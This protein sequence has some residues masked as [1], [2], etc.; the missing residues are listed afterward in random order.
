MSARLRFIILGISLMVCG[1]A[2]P[3]YAAE[4][5]A[6]W[7]AKAVSVQG[8]VEVQRAGHSAWQATSL[9]ATIC[10]GD[11]IRVGEKG[12]AGL[13]LPNETVV[14]LDQNSFITLSAV[15]EEGP[16]LLDL[17]RGAAHFI[18]RVPRALK[19]KT[20]YVN[21][22]IEGT[23]FTIRVEGD[24]ATIIVFEGTVRAEN[25]AG[26]EILIGGE[27]AIAKAGQSPRKILVAQPRDAVD[28]ALY[29]PPVVDL[30]RLVATKPAA[31]A[32]ALTASFARFRQGDIAGAFARLEHLPARLRDANFHIYSASLFLYVGRVDEAREAIRQALALEP[33]SGE[34]IALQAI[35]AVSQD[36]RDEAMRLAQTAVELAPDNAAPRIA[37]S[38]AHQSRFALQAALEDAETAVALE[39]ENTLAWARLAELRLSLGKLDAALDAASQATKL[40]PDL[41]RTQSILGYAYLLRFAASRAQDTFNK[42]IVLDQSDPLPRLGIGLAHI[43]MGHLRDGRREIEIAAGLDPNN[44]LIRSYLGKAYFEEK[45]DSLA[46]SQFDMAKALDPMD[47][48]PW[49][50]DA[51]RKQTQNRPSEALDDLKQSIELNDNRAVYRSRLLLDEDLA[52]REASIARIYDNLGFEQLGTNKSTQSLSLDPT[53][54]SA[55]RFLADSH[56]RQPRLETARVSELLQTQLLQPINL[57][58]VQPQLAETNLNIITGSGPANP[59][60]NEFTPL[61]AMDGFQLNASGIAGNND[62]RGDEVVL[63]GIRGPF[64]F[65]LGQFYYDTDGFRD[66]ADIQHKIYNVFVQAALSASLDLQF[67]FRRRDTDQGDLRLIF[68]PNFVPSD[69]QELEQDIYRA[70]LHAQ[71]SPQ[72][73][74]LFSAIYSDRDPTVETVLPG[75]QLRE[76]GDT[77][78]YDLQ[79][80]YLHRAERFNVTAGVG[81]YDIDLD[82]TTTVSFGGFGPPPP[83][84]D[85]F[86]FNVEQ[87]N[88]YLYTNVRGPADTLWTLGLSYDSID[89]ELLDIDERQFN[90]KLG[91]QWAITDR[92]S[93]RGA[94]LR[95][96]K[97]LLIANQTIEPT[98][99]AGF[100]QFF[101]DFNAT[102]ARVYGIG[103]DATLQTTL[104]TGA[105]WFSRSLDVPVVPGGVRRVENR[106]E[107][108]YRAYLYWN[109]RSDWAMT[110]QFRFEE[111][112]NEARNP[113]QLKTTIVPLTLRYFSP[114]GPFAQ[115]GTSYVRQNL[116]FNP[117]PSFSRRSE[118][119]VVVDA[120]VGY[121]LP[122]RR[123]I[124]SLEA[125]NLFDEDFL[126]QDLS[127]ANADPF[128]FNPRF[129]PDRAILGRLTLSF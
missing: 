84:P 10:P 85:R 21:A 102:E 13:I 29:Y 37:R 118:E 61:F 75:F 43:R 27:S 98:Q 42:A 8:S 2:S 81:T 48:T 72:S 112:R 53:N 82:G 63:S 49:F 51:I 33:A 106:N 45:R 50:Y 57:H 9:G 129:V 87:Y 16:S 25:T 30:Q 79:A 111:F 52:A 7:A 12:R 36:D 11:S 46:A 18:S 66:D 14:R 105:E 69:T 1:H 22:A 76:E 89:D 28:W 108:I 120:A 77:D 91:L 88:G 35:I 4:A 114:K 99:V 31:T 86:G 60:F 70:G 113:A 100:T 119:F 15:E 103:L 83:P 126:Y 109:P 6:S 116:D 123:G 64:S 44:S 38:Y 90:P 34:A 23:E 40:N 92:L 26:R 110:A 101:D 71:V 65:S 67:E 62:T 127:F 94:A 47:P 95:T 80:Q 19:I 54:Y 5:C 93:L 115:L 74:L 122:K 107:D 104:S 59:A 96:L 73:D 56:L 97:R 58:P 124:L 32:D 20:P 125:S 39:A 3:T 55:H 117:A 17:L 41:S 121:R 128:K 68:D 24:T 78:G